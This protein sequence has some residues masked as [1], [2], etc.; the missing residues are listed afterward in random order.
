MSIAAEVIMT[1]ANLVAGIILARA[2]GAE[3][4]GVFALAMTVAAAAAAMLGLRGDR[5]AG[6][7]LARDVTALPM[8][9]VSVAGMAGVASGLAALVIALAPSGVALMF[10]GIDPTVASLAVWL[11]GT[12]CL[13]VGIAAIYGG[14][15][16]FAGRS[17][18][19]L[20]Y[21]IAQATT[22]CVLWLVGAHD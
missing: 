12:Q 19:L 13:Y 20:A 4:K 18:F 8:I 14:L 2:V 17:R 11:V 15:R 10:R 1:V 16:D 21:N 5:P 22:V 9:V 6:H 3:G 7:F